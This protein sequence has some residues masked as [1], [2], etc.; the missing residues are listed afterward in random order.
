MADHTRQLLRWLAAHDTPDRVV[1]LCDDAPLPAVARGT[2]VVRLLGCLADTGVGL[3]AQLLA[4]GVG[5][6]E[7]GPC[8]SRPDEA[9]AHV[10]GWRRVLSERVRPHAAPRRLR[11][12]RPVVLVLGAVP[13]PRRVLLGLG[14]RDASPLDLDLDDAAR[15]LVA[16]RLLGADTRL[17]AARPPTTDGD[18]PTG[19]EPTSG[20]AGPGS[21]AAALAVDGCVA[22]G[23]CVRACPHDA[24]VLEHEGGTSTLRHAREACRSELECLRLCPAG[25]FSTS[26]PVPL[27]DVLT[28]PL[29]TLAEVATAACTRCGARHPSDGGSLC[30]TCRFREGNAFGSSL[31][32]GLAARLARERGDVPG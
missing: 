7:A 6:V 5:A 4:S 30:P 32:P 8:P 21:A 15:T 14:M 24:L 10:A 29:V 2:V 12:G 11:R 19:P 22:C 26:G 20:P 3:P 27:A 31:P 13:L 9:A 1:L 18:L 17:A 23:V 16:L 28:E 25:A